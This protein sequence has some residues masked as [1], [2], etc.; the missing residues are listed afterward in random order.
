MAKRLSLAQKVRRM[1]E[2]G[3]TTQDIVAKLKVKPQVV[4]NVRYQINK[5]K[6]LDALGHSIPKPVTGIGA[7]PKHPSRKAKVRTGITAPVQQPVEVP[8][9][10]LWGRIKRW[11]R[12]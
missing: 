12:G 7:L 10:S 1:V 6:G 2:K 4:Y 3:Y 9:I 8:T 5:G 11:L